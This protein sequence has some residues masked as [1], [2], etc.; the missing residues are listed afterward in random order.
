MSISLSLLS[1]MF[2]PLYIDSGHDE[3][4]YLNMNLSRELWK[5]VKIKMLKV[6][7]GS[8]WYIGLPFGNSVWNLGD[9]IGFTFLDILFRLIK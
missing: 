4:V 7:D 5:D 3:M 9:L 6:L 8:A 2:T 1:R